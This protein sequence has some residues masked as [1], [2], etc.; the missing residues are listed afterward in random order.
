MGLWVAIF[1]TFAVL[2]SI[3]WI[4][5]S[6]R[7]RVLIEYR[8]LA[9]SK[10][11]K[12]RILDAKLAEQLFP[13]IDN[14]RQFVFY[15]KNL[16]ISAKPNNHKAIVVRVSD[17]PNAHEIDEIDQIRQAI[18]A[19]IGFKDLPSSAEAIIISASGLSVLWREGSV[20]GKTVKEVV[21]LIDGFLSK[22]IQ[23]SNIWT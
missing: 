3:L 23:N 11:I 15:E 17:D 18:L 10:G 4:K 12:V 1:I 2:G 20:E 22:L 5:P 7:E 16:P 14:Y 6:P 21:E 8:N 9:L 13:W 19:S